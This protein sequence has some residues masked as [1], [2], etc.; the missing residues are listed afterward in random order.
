MEYSGYVEP[1]GY[2]EVVVR[3]DVDRREFIAFWLRRG[4]VLVGMNVNIWDVNDTIQ[5]LV[6]AGQ[7]VDKNALRDPETPLESLTGH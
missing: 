7:P 3:G 1:D 6:R 4:Q 5:A 2:D